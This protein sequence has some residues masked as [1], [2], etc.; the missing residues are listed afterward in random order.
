MKK[1]TIIVYCSGAGSPPEIGYAWVFM[2]VAVFAV[3]DV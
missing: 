3:T 2:P 1:I